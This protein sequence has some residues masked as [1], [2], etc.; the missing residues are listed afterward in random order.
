MEAWILIGLVAMIFLLLT[1]ATMFRK[2]GSLFIRVAIG[3]LFL[4]FLN[5]IGGFFDY[6]LPF[7][8]LTIGT[9]A[10]LGV[11]WIIALVC[12]DIFLF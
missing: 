10:W 3:M 12:A 7:N 9:A 5:T 8:S 1:G 11:P 6:R 2:L 4:F